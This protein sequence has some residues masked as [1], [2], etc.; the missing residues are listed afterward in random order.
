MNTSSERPVV[1][2]DE[3]LTDL[4]VEFVIGM[5]RSASTDRIR[6]VDWWP[7]AKAALVVAA[8]VAETWAQ[9]V[10]RMGRKLQIDAT[11][12]ATSDVIEVI[13]SRLRETGSFE[14][15]RYLCQRDALYVVAMAQAKRAEQRDAAAIEDESKRQEEATDDDS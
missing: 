1:L 4:A 14:R 12:Y 2:A 10:S 8:S 13:G 9:F 15:F 7:R 6:P 11:H 3:A 5:L